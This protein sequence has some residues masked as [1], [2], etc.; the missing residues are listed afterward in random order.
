MQQIKQCTTDSGSV[1]DL[2]FCNSD[3]FCD[4]IEAYWSDHK[5]VY[6]AIDR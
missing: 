2:I 1:L 5:L 4:V 3:G 6:C